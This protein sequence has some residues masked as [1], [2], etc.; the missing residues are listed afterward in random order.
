MPEDRLRQLFD[1]AASLPVDVPSVDRVLARG[2][3]RRRRARLQASTIAWTI[4][5]AAGFGAPQVSGGLAEGTARFGP[6]V[7][8][9]GAPQASSSPSA[10]AGG[11]TAGPDS[12]SAAPAGTHVPVS[13]ASS[14]TGGDNT[15]YQAAAPLP[16]PGRGRLILGLDRAHSY[17]MTRIGSASTPVRVTGLQAVAGVPPV[18]A[19]NPSGGWVVMLA[20]GSRARESAPGRLALVARSGRSVPFGPLFG[21]ATVTSAA[22]SQDGSR[23]AVAVAWPTGGARIE[24]LP[25]PGRQVAGQSWS[26]PSAQADLVTDLSWS[27]DGR[28]LSYLAGQSASQGSAAG[29]V[30]LDTSAK[31]AAAPQLARWALT[32]KTGLT[33]VS[34]AAAWLGTSGEFAVL[35]ECT[36]TGLVVLQ[37]SDASTG[38]AVGQPIV[39]THRTGCGPAALNSNATGSTVL[40]S[41]CGVYLDDDGKLSR[42]S[43]SLTA[44]ALSG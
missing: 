21:H 36:S 38:A 24:V 37:T 31:V 7:P 25:L 26:V 14:P 8:T 9:A 1:Q 4:M 33:C 34:R 18:L 3:Q 13:P 20:S 10:R 15:T 11:T 5:L 42:E 32:M 27:P 23:V 2:K 22:V 19:T 17:V 6:F 16:P 44:A 43:A 12:A 35:S 40:I 29:P 28:R 39:V 30:I 41:Y